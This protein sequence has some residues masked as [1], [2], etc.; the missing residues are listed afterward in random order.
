MRFSDWQFAKGQFIQ[1]G[2]FQPDHCIIH[3]DDAQELIDTAEHHARLVE[4][5]VGKKSVATHAMIDGVP[6]L[7][8]DG[9]QVGQPVFVVRE[10]LPYE[11]AP[12][13][14]KPKAPRRR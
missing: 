5:K 13:Y 11:A 3:P 2:G 1:A 7:M 14:Q 4:R 12:A 6:V 8:Q 10:R 9:A